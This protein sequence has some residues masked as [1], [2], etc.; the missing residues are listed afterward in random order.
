MVLPPAPDCLHCNAKRFHLKPPNFCCSGGQVSLVNHPMPYALQQLF[1]GTDDDSDQF[2]KN[3][4][5][6]NNNFAFTSLGAKY[7]R[8]LTKNTRGMYTFHVQGQVYHFLNALLSDSE[9]Q[10]GIRLISYMRVH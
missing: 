6:Y 8:D 3:V 7:D 2:R 5:T 9:E 4:R 1:T 10:A